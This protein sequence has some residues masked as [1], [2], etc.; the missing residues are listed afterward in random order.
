MYDQF[1]SVF[2]LLRDM[3]ELMPLLAKLSYILLL[4]KGQTPQFVTAYHIF[5]SE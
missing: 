5:D 1:A 3:I 2:V 4:G